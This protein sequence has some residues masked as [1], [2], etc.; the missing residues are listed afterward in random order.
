MWRWAFLVVLGLTK[1]AFAYQFAQ[2]PTPTSASLRHR[3]LTAGERRT[4]FRLKYF[5]TSPLPN[6]IGWLCYSDLF[7]V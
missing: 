1:K 2:C 6:A 5:F 4:G 7:S 3:A